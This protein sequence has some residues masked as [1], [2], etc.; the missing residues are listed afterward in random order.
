M[1]SFSFNLKADY[2]EAPLARRMIC[3]VLQ[4]N[5]I[6][7]AGCVELVSAEILRLTCA[8][9]LDQDFVRWCDSAEAP[10]AI[11]G[12]ERKW[13]ELL[14]GSVTSA[15]YSAHHQACFLRVAN[16]LPYWEMF[17]MTP[18]C[19]QHAALDGFV[20]KYDDPVWESIYPPNGWMCGCSVGAIAASD[21]NAARSGTR[22]VSPELRKLCS[23]WLSRRP[24][25]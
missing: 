7:P 13:R 16:A 8:G 23:T 11:S 21:P 24:H 5:G 12:L 6:D 1:A 14:F 10:Q 3:R 22:E 18:Y 17:C 19:A 4:W 15:T 2:L 20:A 25:L 9:R